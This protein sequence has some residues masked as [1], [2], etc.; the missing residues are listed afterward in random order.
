MSELQ[1]A[2]FITALPA[3]IVSTLVIVLSAI[4]SKENKSKNKQA[5]KPFVNTYGV[6]INR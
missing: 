1:I 5:G 3:A 2:I 6:Y 4:D